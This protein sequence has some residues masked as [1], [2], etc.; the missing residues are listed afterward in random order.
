[1]PEDDE[2]KHSLNESC[3]SSKA[4]LKAH[5]CVHVYLNSKLALTEDALHAIFLV[6]KV[7]YFSTRAK[8]GSRASRMKWLPG[9]F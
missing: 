7:K 5:A 6:P 9:I 8:Q 3:T 1:V 2:A 4:P